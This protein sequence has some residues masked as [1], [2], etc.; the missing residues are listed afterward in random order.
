VLMAGLRDTQKA[1]SAAPLP[2]R[3]SVPRAKTFSVSR[4]FY[5]WMV[6]MMNAL[7]LFF[8]PQPE[9]HVT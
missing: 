6:V 1:S 5:T 8:Y 4:K 3:A 2:N 7:L 9:P